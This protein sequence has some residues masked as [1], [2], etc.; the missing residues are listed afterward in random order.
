M[1]LRINIDANPWSLRFAPISLTKPISALRCGMFTNLE[2]YQLLAPEIEIGHL[3]D[4]HLITLFPS[5]SDAITVC[6][7]IV[8]NADF[9]MALSK[10][11]E[12]DC[13]KY[14]GKILAYVKSADNDI[15]YVG[16]PMVELME[17]WDLF[18]KNEQVLKS[19]FHLYTKGKKSA[20][21]PTHCTLIGD[22]NFLFIE[23]GSVQSASIFNTTNGPI[24]LG[25]G[26]EVMEGSMVRGALALCDYAQL[27]MGTKIYGA[28]TIGP[29]CKVGGEVNNVIF[30]SYSNKS[31]DG[32][33]GNGYIGSWCNI[34]ADTNASNL[35]NNYGVVDVHCYE[36]GKTIS[37]SE[38]F[39]GLFM[40]DHSKCG[41]NTMFNTGTMIGV[42]CNVYGPGF[43][44]KHIAS[45][46]FGEPTRTVAYRFE[47]ALDGMESMM[48]RRGKS[49]TILE[50]E[51]LKYLY[52]KR[53]L[54]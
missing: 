40:G 5:I 39:V 50:K 28:C 32:F 53:E 15:Q 48:T 49:L 42:A 30:E 34:G 11:S 51:M 29:H 18:K 8:P 3:L 24:Y 31:H 9:I 23:E 25:K 13:L 12:G 37:S 38:Q 44:K 41:I 20:P 54:F 2:R 21:L 16:E 35:M 19:D 33:L 7:S 10:L 36:T 17:R 22:P 1:S 46:S 6:G 43:F 47:K 45:F 26:T 52:E 4:N 27:K 14:N